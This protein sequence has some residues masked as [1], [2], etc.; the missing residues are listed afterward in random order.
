MTVVLAI[1]RKRARMYPVLLELKC[2]GWQLAVPT[3]SAALAIALVIFCITG[4]IGLQR[5]GL[6]WAIAAAYVL[7]VVLAT[8]GRGPRWLPWH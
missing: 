3:Y 8:A 4:W 1:R 6:G 5:A 2:F 7:A